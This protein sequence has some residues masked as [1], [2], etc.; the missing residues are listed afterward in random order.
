MGAGPGTERAEACTLC[1]FAL[2]VRSN[3]ERLVKRALIDHGIEEFLP[4]YTEECKWSDRVKTIERLLFPGYVFARFV[5]EQRGPEVI[6]I[7]GV[8]QILGA[9]CAQELARVR[10]AVANQ[11]MSIKP[12]DYAVGE[13]V[14]V[15]NGPLAGLEGVVVRTKGQRRIVVSV[16]ILHRAVSVELDP[17]TLTHE[18]REEAEAA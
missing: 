14:T 15:A 16:E 10:R 13:A 11:Q 12:C 18:K 1:W 7:R 2:R 17:E 4:T 5:G 9:V 8:V 3:Q 6:R